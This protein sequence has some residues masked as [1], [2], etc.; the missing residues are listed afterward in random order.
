MS[1]FDF[2]E[3]PPPR[4]ASTIILNFLTV[5]L[6]L[7]VVIIVGV[8]LAIF[9]NPY[10]G[11][12]P[13]PP[14][15]LPT[16]LEL[17]SPTP[18]SIIQFAPS[19]TPTITSPATATET[20]RPTSTLPPSPTSFSIA[21]LTPTVTETPVPNG[22][23]FEVQKGSPVAI[24]NI[25]HPEAGCNWMGIGGQVVEMSGGP[26]IG[27]IIRLGGILPG[28]DIPEHLTSLT[29]VALNYGRAGYEFTLADHPIASNDS[30]WVQ[31]L[32]QL[33]VPISKKVFFNTYESCDK[34]LIIINFKQ[35]R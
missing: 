29:G 28:V 16:P 6:M 17:P 3:P 27:L 30:L 10:S 14:P 5:L 22:Y 1:A 21:S 34:N 18:T 9:T 4:R 8:F 20:L 12:N 24:Q 25:Y 15:I 2:E 19:W 13:F 33:G 7:G 26:V 32:N 31:L 35:V 23:A 11:L